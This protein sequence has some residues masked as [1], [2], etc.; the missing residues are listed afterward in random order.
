[1]TIF[2]SEGNEMKL[3]EAYCWAIAHAAGQSRWAIQVPLC[4]EFGYQLDSVIYTYILDHMYTRIQLAKNSTY[5]GLSK[6]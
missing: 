2:L 5:V 4:R 3:V 1:M 6:N